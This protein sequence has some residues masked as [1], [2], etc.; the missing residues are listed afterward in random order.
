MRKRILSVILAFLVAFSNAFGIFATV[1]ETSNLLKKEFQIIENKVTTGSSIIEESV[2][3]TTPSNIEIKNKGEAVFVVERSTLGQP[4]YIEPTVIEFT[5]GENVAQALV[6]L[7]GEGNYEHTG[8]PEQGFYLSQVKLNDDLSLKI[9]KHILDYAGITNE[10]VEKNDDTWLGEFDHS[11]MSGWIYWVNHEH[12]PVGMSEPKLKDGDVVRLQFTFW[13]YGADLGQGSWDPSAPKYTIANKDALIKQIAYINQN[14][15][16][17]DGN[18]ALKEAYEQSENLIYDMLATQE[19]IDQAVI[20][21]QEASKIHKEALQQ[22]IIRAE[23]VKQSGYTKESVVILKQTL[24]AASIANHSE[25]STQNT[26]DRATKELV[27]AIDRLVLKSID[28]KTALETTLSHMYN[29]TKEPSYGTFDGEWTMLSLARGNYPYPQDYASG[30]YNRVAKVVEDK[31]GV[32]HKRKYTEYSRVVL[33]LTAIG[34]DVTDVAGYNMLAYLADFD[35]VIWQG[36]NG[37]I[38]ALIAFDTYDYE[39]PNK[40]SGKTQTTRDLLVNNILTQEIP[41]GGFA[42]MGKEPDSDIT[43]MALQAL[44][45]YKDRED[46][47]L[48]I[49]R[50]LNVLSKKQ[51]SEGDFLSFEKI[52]TCESTAQVIVALCGLGIDPIKDT[53]FIKNGKNPIDGLLKYYVPEGG[54]KHIIDKPIDAMATDQ[55]AY[56][57]VAYDRMRSQKNSLYNMKD[58]KVIYSDK[59]ALKAQIDKATHLLELDYTLE[60]WAEMQMRLEKAIKIWENANAKQSEVNEGTV[61]LEQ[62]IKQLK[63]KAIQELAISEGQV[64]IPS[65]AKETHYQITLATDG[66][67]FKISIPKT[68][69][70]KVI[71]NTSQLTEFPE[72]EAVKGDYSIR[73]PKGIKIERGCNSIEL[74]TEKTEA[75]KVVIAEQVKELIG[76]GIKA[77]NVDAVCKFGNH[78]DVIFNDYVELIFKGLKGKE[79]SFI[80]TSSK[81]YK[82]DKVSNNAVGLTSGKPEYAY[83]EGENLIVKTKHLT[84]FVVYTAIKDDATDIPKP[85]LE[86]DYVTL[87]VDKLTINKDYT[88]KPAQVPFTRGENVWDVLQREM[89]KRGLRYEYEFTAKYDSVYVQS[90]EGD[91]EFDHG[92]W[93]GWMYNVNN[94]YPNYGA[95]KYILQPGDVIEWRYTT[96][97]GTDLDVDNSAW[98]TWP[99]GRPKDPKNP[100]DANNPINPNNPNI[101]PKIDVPKPV[102]D[103]KF[104]FLEGIKIDK[105]KLIDYID[106]D[107]IANW[108]LQSVDIAT[109]LDIIGGYEGKFHPKKPITKA[110][111]IKAIITILNLSNHAVYKLNFEDVS[112]EDWFAKDVQAAYEG[113]IITEQNGKLNPNQAITREEM[114]IIL[115]QALKLENRTCGDVIKDLDLVAQS[116]KQDVKNAYAY[117]LM[118]GNEGYFNPKGMVTREMAAA[119]IVRTYKFNHQIKTPEIGE[120]VKVALDSTTQYI[121]ETVREPIIGSIGGEWAV[122]GLAR[123]NAKVPENYYRDYYQKVVQHAKEETAKTNRRWKTKVTETQ[124]IAIALAAIGKDP[125]N[126]EGINLVNYSWNKA[127]NMP[128]LSEH[129]QI[130]GNRQ[131]LNELVF[132]LITVDLKGYKQPEDTA[133]TRNEMINK[134]LTTYRTQD[135]GFNLMEGASKADVDM[136]AMTLQSLAPYCGVVGYEHVTKAVEEALGT[137]AKEQRTD[138]GFENAY[139]GADGGK[140]ATSEST[141]Q[142]IVA[143]CALKIDPT[144]DVRFTKNGKNPI[145]NLMSYAV[146]GGGFKHL[147]EA[148]VDQMATEQAYYALVAYERFVNGQTPLYDMRK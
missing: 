18:D 138:G 56:A 31:K 7:L 107:Q 42:L 91:G 130:L 117:N 127:K 6:R 121:I 66:P 100:T 35:N 140:A 146:D 92:R 96:N 51:T 123:R 2:N 101:L 39:I 143:L 86:Q 99:D 33:G 62:G 135:G 148:T 106:K 53:R 84:D 118:K 21:V 48:C 67:N 133:I 105:N 15:T 147:K 22:A 120:N 75:Q 81:M 89:D 93:S 110:E 94:W 64:T 97:L 30:Y 40:I 142:V 102:V 109:G 125:T 50:A 8:T 38:F 139:G 128:D 44:A 10:D 16:I 111:W 72:I 59:I 85:P 34:K 36:I 137:L 24:E 68:H 60:S 58:V 108:A 87:S 63:N 9:P 114:V 129:D 73:F 145:D 70:H 23:G 61:F 71:L 25:D 14:K 144:Q 136:T 124:R 27:Q 1:P 98:D 122:F 17:L 131:G 119:V 65:D 45:P 74:F 52:E 82:I 141:A 12:M 78:E 47:G 104:I 49:E 80:D 88:I 4:F 11:Y 69:L 29:T 13:G 83:D 43:G 54:F 20:D 112:K 41:G 90:I 19:T 32:L 5:E 116:A 76:V 28:Y 134:I 115:S 57:L 132:G 26:I 55:G 46:V 37:P 126:V 95:S 77:S 103:D 3:K 113:G 79:I